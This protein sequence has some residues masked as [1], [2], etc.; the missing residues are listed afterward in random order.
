MP[1]C[2]RSVDGNGPKTWI[3]MLWKSKKPYG[4]EIKTKQIGWNNFSIQIWCARRIWQ[5][6]WLF[7]WN[8]T[9]MNALNEMRIGFGVYGRLRCYH[10]LYFKCCKRW[11]ETAKLT[12]F[13]FHIP[14]FSCLREKI[15][16]YLRIFLH[17]TLWSFIAESLLFFPVRNDR[18]E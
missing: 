18:H 16:I 13:A 2:V 14:E 8:Y 15:F 6:I 5:K 11:T 17:L 10:I 9:L 12:Q 3:L 1:C 4:R 7:D